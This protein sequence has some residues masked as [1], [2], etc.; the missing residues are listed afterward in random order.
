MQTVNKQSDNWQPLSWAM[1]IGSIVGA[2]VTGLGKHMDTLIAS[3][4]AERFL[5]LLYAFQVLYC[6]AVNLPKYSIVALYWRVFG[7]EN[8]KWP[9]LVVSAIIT[10]NFVAVVGCLHMSVRRLC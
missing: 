8:F 4:Q 3:H 2:T 9:L 7:F 10:V 1:C 6:V 5:V